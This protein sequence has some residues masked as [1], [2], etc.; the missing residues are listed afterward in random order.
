[1]NSK[2]KIRIKLI[3]YKQIF[4]IPPFSPTIKE[5]IINIFFI[6]QLRSIRHGLELKCAT[7]TSIHM[8]QYGEDRFH[9]PQGQE[10]REVWAGKRGVGV[11]YPIKGEKKRKQSRFIFK[12]MPGVKFNSVPSK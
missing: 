2:K 11:D 1:M 6:Q 7:Y 3:I 10:I 4:Q 5:K 9:A 8:T 12:R